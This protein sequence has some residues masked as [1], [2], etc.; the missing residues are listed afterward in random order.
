[1]ADMAQIWRD[2]FRDAK[3]LSAEINAYNVQ[4]KPCAKCGCAFHESKMLHTALG[5]FCGDE[6]AAEWEAEFVTYMA[7]EG[8]TVSQPVLL[9]QEGK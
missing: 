1:M 7:K 3:R 2:H 4:W 5:D 6:C 8:H 9:V